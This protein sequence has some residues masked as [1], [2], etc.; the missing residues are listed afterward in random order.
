M[1]VCV[2]VCTCV[3]IPTAFRSGD[4]IPF[5]L[6]CLWTPPFSYHQLS[7]AEKCSYDG[8]GISLRLQ[9]RTPGPKSLP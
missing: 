1:C 4:P 5:Q 3:H 9:A 2:C 6:H 7:L 8:G